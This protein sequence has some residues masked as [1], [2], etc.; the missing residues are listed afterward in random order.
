MNDYLL[1]IVV[2][3]DALA[4]RVADLDGALAD[5]RRREL[6]LAAEVAALRMGV[7]LSI[8]ALDEARRVISAARTTQDRRSQSVDDRRLHAI[9]TTIRN[10]ALQAGSDLAR[11]AL[12][13]ANGDPRERKKR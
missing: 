4:E 2:E 12:A 3:R 1:D 6:D 10:L 5:A 8:K 7:A 11:H 9:H 13:V